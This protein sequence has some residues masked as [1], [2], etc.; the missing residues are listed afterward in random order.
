[1][2][3]TCQLSSVLANS[4]ADTQIPRG[5]KIRRMPPESSISGAQ[6][7]SSEGISGEPQACDDCKECRTLATAGR[8]AQLVSHDLRNHLASINANVEFISHYRIT[9]LEQE[10][11]LEEMRAV[12]RDM[13]RML[14]SLLVHAKTGQSLHPRWDSIND[15]VE[16]A[17]CM[18]RAHP[19]ARNVDLMLLEAENVMCWMDSTKLGSAIYNLLL[20]ACQAARAGVAPRWVR[21][22]LTADQLFVHVRVIDS[23]YGV[24]ATI[25]KTLFQPFVSTDRVNGTGL[26]LSIV[27]RTAKEHGGYVDLEESG[28][29]RTVFALH[30]SKYALENMA[31]GPLS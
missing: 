31:S 30:I 20:N 6:F 22:K 19:D 17:A 12:I 8:M 29:G 4:S 23:G 3:A 11:L 27:D 21:V 1:M 14:D 24:S 28:H 18:V 26:G 13:T 9:K 25:Q 7:A 5:S 2:N 15:V 10:E 16:H